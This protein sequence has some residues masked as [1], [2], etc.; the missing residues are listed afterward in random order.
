MCARILRLAA[1]LLLVAG[2]AQ[3]QTSYLHF[4]SGPVRPIVLSDDGSRLY[5]TNISDNRLEIY[6]VS[7]FGVLTH[8]HSV[9]VGMEPVAVAQNG[10]EVWVVNHLSDSVS[11]VDT[12]LDPPVVTRTLLV[13]DEPRDIVFAGSGTGRAFISTAHRGQ[14][15]TDGTI[16]G[17]TGAGDPQ[18]TTPGVGRADVWVFDAANPGAAYGGTPDEILSFFGDTP[19]ALATDG[20]KVWVAVFHSGNQ[21]TTVSE[22]AVCDGFTGAGSCTVDGGL[23][24]GGNPGPIDNHQN[25]TAPE[26]GLI[27]Q[28]DEA[29]GEWRDELNRDWTPQVRF[30]LPDNDVFAFDADT[31]ATTNTYDHVGT[32]LFNMVVNPSSGN[33]YVSNGDSQNLTRFEGA[34]THGG[35]T[36]Q[37][38]LAQYGISVLSGAST[39]DTRH[40]N[41]HINYSLLPAPAGTKNH[42]VATPLDMVTNSLGTKL[43]VA[44]FGSDIV[45][46]YDVATLENDTF[47][48]TVQ[49]AQHIAVSGGGPSGLAFL[50]T[51]NRMFVYNRYTNSIS[52][53]NTFAGVEI[54]S[55]PLPHNPEPSTVTDGRRMLYD[56][57]KTSSNGEASCSSCHVFGDLDSL[58]WDLGDPDGDVTQNVMPLTPAPILF[59]QNGGA[60]D[61]EFHPMKGPMTTQTLRG[62]QNSGGMHWR[63]DR[64][65]GFFGQDVP[66]STGGG[67]DRGDESLNFDNF[68]VAF[69]GLVGGATPAT[70]VN[71]QADMF[72]F[73]DF[74]LEIQLPPNPIRNLN[75]SD[76]ASQAAGRSLYFGRNT[77]IV[78]DCNGCHNLDPAN[79]F[80]GTGGLTSFENETQMMK[81]AHL[82]N[83]YQKV[84]MFGMPNVPFNIAGDGSHQGPQIRGFGFL[85]DGSTD[86]VF[87]FFSATVFNNLP[88]IFGFANAGERRDM[89]DFM[90]AFDS[91]LAPI[92]GQQIT[93]DGSANIDMVLRVNL[94][95]ARA[96]AAFTSKILGGA[97]TECDVIAKA[98]V[99]G[100]L[101]GYV[102]DPGP[103]TYTPDR[104][105]EPA[106]T[107]AQMEA[108]ADVAGQ[109]VT[110]TCAPPGSGVRMG[111][112]RDLDGRLDHDEI[113]DG[114]DPGNAGSIVGACNDGIDNDGDGSIDLADSGCAN[115]GSS[116]EN[117]QCSD[118]VDNDSDGQVDGGDAKCQNDADN[119][120]KNNP[121]CGLGFE[122]AL[123]LLPLMALRRR[124]PRA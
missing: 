5:V 40:L 81:V 8:L 33:V 97:V 21:T 18:L 41:K 28:F 2:V 122:A 34:G 63:G 50:E 68:I 72:D 103:N 115:A 24:P 9:P 51:A 42:S 73:T 45:A 117:P 38:N 48:P 89:E 4:E 1:V 31:L 123:A 124:R 32:I 109:Y 6:F 49:S 87:R 106:L 91:D 120:E 85:H 84:G 44:G 54:G 93:D 53:L 107:E 55:T 67:T 104:Q 82:R 29:S 52:T 37:G 27:V 77:D 13:G 80:F 22:G 88:G 43:Y 46:V 39:V 16:A 36:V 59:G 47:D 26:T 102:Y 92:V 76:T 10:D 114:T 108:I 14:H 119:D 118:G 86:T 17:V 70:D 65:D 110:Y 100:E 90:L 25:I 23:S 101:R 64:V 116:I 66:Y 30:D 7:Q 57:F 11:I 60:A 99:G 69:P 105:G 95:E 3:A 75:N 35:S 96:G 74:A 121:G 83:Q 15:R 19:R 78:T 113:D 98:N 12:S 79:G 56:A 94:L 71:L 62:M 20:S 112:D 111:I 61:D 58:A